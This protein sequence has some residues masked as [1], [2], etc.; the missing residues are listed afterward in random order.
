MVQVTTREK[1]D[2][3]NLSSGV[4]GLNLEDV[5]S[6]LLD[7]F[8]SDYEY[9]VRINDL[10]GSRFK[11]LPKLTEEDRELLKLLSSDLWQFVKDDRIEKKIG[12][13]DEQ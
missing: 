5:D 7:N 12:E 8:D 4:S 1:D 6:D 13:M 11:A 10:K 9:E 2:L 3:N